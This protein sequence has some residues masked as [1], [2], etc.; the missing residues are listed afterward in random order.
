MVPTNNGGGVV[1]APGATQFVIPL[2]ATNA[3]DL[4]GLPEN[5]RNVLIEQHSRNVVELG[6]VAQEIN[7]QGAGLAATMGTLSGTVEKASANG[8][9]ATATYKNQS[10]LGNVEVIIGNTETAK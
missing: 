5:Q 10:A 2:G 4:S 8:T 3:I 9:A 6:K 7:I 1:P